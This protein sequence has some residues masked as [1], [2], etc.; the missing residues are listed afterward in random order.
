MHDK[1]RTPLNASGPP[2]RPPNGSQARNS[3][4][5]TRPTTWAQNISNKAG[6]AADF[7]G[8]FKSSL[9]DHIKKLKSKKIAFTKQENANNSKKTLKFYK[10][11]KKNIPAPNNE[12]FNRIV[13]QYDEIE[14]LGDISIHDR[15]LV[16]RVLSDHSLSRDE[17]DQGLTASKPQIM[18]TYAS[19]MYSFGEGA[20]RH[21]VTFKLLQEGKVHMVVSRNQLR[22]MAY[23][24]LITTQTGTITTRLTGKPFDIYQSLGV[25]F[26]TT[27]SEAEATMIVNVSKSMQDDLNAKIHHHVFSDPESEKTFRLEPLNLP[28]YENVAIARLV[29]PEDSINAVSPLAIAELTSGPHPNTILDTSDILDEG[30]CSNGEPYMSIYL[31]LAVNHEKAPSRFFISEDLGSSRFEICTNVMFCF[32]CNSRNHLRSRC[33][34]A[35]QCKHCGIRSHPTWRCHSSEQTRQLYRAHKQERHVMNLKNSYHKDLEKKKVLLKKTTTTTQVPTHQEKQPQ[36]VENKINSP[37]NHSTQ[38]SGSN[39]QGHSGAMY[40]GENI[41]SEGQRSSEISHISGSSNRQ[42]RQ[43]DGSASAETVNDSS[44]EDEAP[45]DDN[46]YEKEPSSFNEPSAVDESS[47][48]VNVYEKEQIGFHKVPDST[49]WDQVPVTDSRMS[50]STVDQQ[51]FQDDSTMSSRLRA[52]K[53]VNYRS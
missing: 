49:S 44:M 26:A 21:L 2:G 48:R 8:P 22:Y 27:F 15:D 19:L 14:E 53:N 52:P 43:R 51:T 39:G 1:E 25:N 28:E 20:T 3:P 10:N 34:V 12:S 36:A 16:F 29:I 13:R 11:P 30:L 40:S 24:H 47:A 46:I 6:A 33:P 31:L 41:N 50:D 35:P 17:I 18:E 37:V 4:S 7:H 32:F 42:N 45:S 5:P 9:F 23:T 38:V